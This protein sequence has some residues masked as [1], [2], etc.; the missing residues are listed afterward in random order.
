MEAIDWGTYLHLN[1]ISEEEEVNSLWDFKTL[2]FELEVSGREC[3]G[4]WKWGQSGGSWFCKA[5][6]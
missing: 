4:K 2:R 5:E 6:A 3:I 1:M